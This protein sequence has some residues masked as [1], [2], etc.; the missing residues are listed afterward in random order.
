MGKRKEQAKERAK[1]M[2]SDKQ[3]DETQHVSKRYAATVLSV[4]SVLIC[5]LALVGAW[6][7]KDYLTE[8]NIERFR[9]FVEKHWFSGS[10]IFMAICFVQVVIA[11]IP[12]EA[13]EIA[14][15]VIFGPFWGTLLCLLGIT[16]GSIVVILLVR[17]F[18]RKFV[19]SLYSRDKIDSIPILNNPKKRNTMVFLLFFIPG[20]PKDLMTYIVGLTEMSIPMYI[21]LTTIARIPSILMSTLGG[22]AV[23]EGKIIKAVVIF[24]LT[25][26]ISGAG[27]LIYTLMQKKMQK[28][29]NRANNE[30]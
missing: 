1:E 13:V 4:V 14:A 7:L 29:E 30:K 20:T 11:F 9:L 26:L 28:K 10:L 12:G 16:L 25:A 23:G 24:A 6:L 5:V 19:E 18:G 2:L 17:L 15:G 3:F 21:I 22:D 27:Y 8:E